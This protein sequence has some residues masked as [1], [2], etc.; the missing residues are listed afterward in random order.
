[1]S[2]PLEKRGVWKVKVTENSPHLKLLM[3]E[4][5]A[6]VLQLDQ[7]ILVKRVEGRKVI[8]MCI[9]VSISS[10]ALSAEYFPKFDAVAVIDPDTIK[11]GKLFIE[12]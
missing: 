2:K 4:N 1:M 6:L 10:T 3:G 8:I 7:P 9:P 12:P 5:N 11:D